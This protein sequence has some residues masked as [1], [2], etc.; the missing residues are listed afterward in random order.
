[1]SLILHYKCDKDILKTTKEATK[2][3]GKS[4]HNFYNHLGKDMKKVVLGFYDQD[5]QAELQSQY[6]HLTNKQWMQYI[7]TISYF[8]RPDKAI[9]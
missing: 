9:D 1:M 6:Q 3:M 8:Y 2:F 7:S 5:K 4:L